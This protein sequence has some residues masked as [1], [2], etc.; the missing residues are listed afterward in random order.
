MTIKTIFRTYLVL[1]C[2]WA[3]GSDLISINHLTHCAFSCGVVTLWKCDFTSLPLTHCNWKT[4]QAKLLE[5]LLWRW[6][7]RKHENETNKNEIS[8]SI[9]YLL[10]FEV[11]KEVCEHAVFFIITNNYWTYIQISEDF[12]E[13]SKHF[14][15]SL[16]V[17][18]T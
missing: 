9:L 18:Y 3:W 17:F 12:L 1:K 7:W 2:R 16:S 14:K 4:K 11:V 6:R 10:R 8:C 5:I 13:I 15:I